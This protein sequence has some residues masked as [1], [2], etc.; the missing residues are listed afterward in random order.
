MNKKCAD[1]DNGKD[2]EL[3]YKEKYIMDVK[4]VDKSYDLFAIKTLDA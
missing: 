1:K 4:K 3:L 2:L